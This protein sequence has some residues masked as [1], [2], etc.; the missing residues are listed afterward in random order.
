M[1]RRSNVF[2]IILFWF[3]VGLWT[4]LDNRLASRIFYQP[5]IGIL[6]FVFLMLW[7]GW[8]LARYRSYKL[9]ALNAL[10]F[11]TAGTAAFFV[12]GIQDLSTWRLGS[13]LLS[14]ASDALLV[15]SVTMLVGSV[16]I[17]F[18]T[19]PLPKISSMNTQPPEIGPLTNSSR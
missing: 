7:S 4:A 8:V 11:S 12:V 5:V 17:K 18:F 6:P 2:L 10:L 14:W 16:R 9:L 13:Q 19:G 1:I 3:A 15:F